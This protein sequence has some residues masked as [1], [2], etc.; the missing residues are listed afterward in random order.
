MS[1]SRKALATLLLA[2]FALPALAHN[3][4]LAL[5]AAGEHVA[6]QHWQ[7]RAGEHP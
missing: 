4:A 6:A 7:Q 1:S 3:L 5:T 2:A